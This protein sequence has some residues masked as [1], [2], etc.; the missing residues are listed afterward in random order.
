[1]SRMAWSPAGSA[2][3]ASDSARERTDRLPS[4]SSARMSTTPTVGRVPTRRSVS[5]PAG[6]PRRGPGGP[7]H[8]RRRRASTSRAPVSATRRRAPTG[9]RIGGSGRPCTRRHGPRP[10]R[11]GRAP[12]P[13]R[14][15]PSGS[16][17]RPALLR[18]HPLPLVVAL[19]SRQPRVQDRQRSPTVARSRSASCG[20]RVS[21]GTST[22]AP[23]PLAA[24]ASTAA[25]TTSVLPEAA[26]PWSRSS[27]PGEGDPP[28][29]RGLFGAR[30]CYRGRPGVRWAK[31][32]RRTAATPARPPCASSRRAGASR[33]SGNVRARGKVR[34]GSLSGPWRP[35]RHAATRP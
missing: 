30:S 12:A 8:V 17:R 18:H 15:P 1:M 27:P 21:S 9:C 11:R 4:A 35:G 5:R 29:C 6:R 25:R 16:R 10:A 23:A 34:Q 14:R 20:T 13:A 22:I 7:H 3:S 28:Q 33:L 32:S 24:V 31:G 19:P 2:A 26:T